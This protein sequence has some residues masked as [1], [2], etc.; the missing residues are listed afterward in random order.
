MS[1][2]SLVDAARAVRSVGVIGAGTM[3]VGIAVSLLSAGYDVVL[4]DAKPDA[5][6]AGATRARSM[7]DSAV[8]KGR[9]APEV[10]ARAATALRADTSLS[11]VADCELVIEAVFE[12]A[13]VKHAVFAELGRVAKPGAVL[14][15]NT[16]TLD[17]DAIAAASGRPADVVGMHFFSPA[18]VMKLVELVRAA[19][20]GEAALATV[21]AVTRRLGKTAVEVGNAFG[22]V[23]NRMLYAY[24]RE[25]ELLMLE[26]ASPEQID[27]AME[28]F[29][30]AMGP[31][32]VSDLAGIDVGVSARREWRERPN[33]PRFFR[34]SEALYE[35]GRY[36]QKNGKGFYRYVDGK[37][38]PDPEVDALIQDE[39]ARLGIARRAVDDAEIVERCTLALVNQGARLLDA[40]IARSAADV[41]AVWCLGYGFPRERGG[42]MRH[43]ESQGWGAVVARLRALRERT[44]DDVWEPAARL[45]RLAG[46]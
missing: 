2:A 12:S 18:H 17:V 37:R 13:A 10:A 28:G 14:A 41:D 29:G 20:S 35:R 44:G 21:A 16:S 7:L 26:G 45:V 46:E 43:A 4:V 11:A 23:G 38:V 19:R 36:G 5:A 1:D 39:A 32:A 30:M 6:A 34:I 15:T 8:A 33:D 9:L 24:G 22:F 42:P 3:G 25:R 27:R 31:N 40:G